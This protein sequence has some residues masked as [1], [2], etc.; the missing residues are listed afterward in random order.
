MV[1]VVMSMV[2]SLLSSRI[3]LGQ[4]TVPPQSGQLLTHRQLLLQWI[5]ITMSND[6]SQVSIPP[7]ALLLAQ[8]TVR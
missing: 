2:V 4:E 3:V 7:P 6:R 5:P 8:V 1:T